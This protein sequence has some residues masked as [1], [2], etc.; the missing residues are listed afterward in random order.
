[1]DLFARLFSSET[2]MAV[3]SRA[4]FLPQP[5][6]CPAGWMFRREHRSHVVRIFQENTP[7]NAGAKPSVPASAIVFS[8]HYNV[9]AIFWPSPPLLLPSQKVASRS[10][11]R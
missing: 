5:E 7:V 9:K 6:K 11:L 8:G 10:Q 4:N 1:M 2:M 3:Q